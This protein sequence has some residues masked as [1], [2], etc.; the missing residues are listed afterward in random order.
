MNPALILALTATPV[1]KRSNVLFHVTAQQL[2]AGHVIKMPISLIEHRHSAG[3]SVTFD[4]S[5]YPV[6]GNKRYRGKFCFSKHFY[7]VLADL[8]DGSEE[9]RCAMA[10]D[11]HA[12]VRFWVRN[13]DSDPMAGFWLPTSLR[14]FYPDFVCQRHDGRL[15]VAE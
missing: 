9:W 5:V 12:L 2:Q 8:A 1:P 10:L 13:P 15:L 3:I 14:H 11:D 6:A 4:P 7:P